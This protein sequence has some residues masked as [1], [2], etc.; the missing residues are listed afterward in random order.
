MTETKRGPGRPKKT[1]EDR[2]TR[3]PLGV[4][5]SKLSVEKKDPNYNYRW[6]NE[7]GDRIPRALEAGYEFVKRDSTDAPGVRD[8]VPQNSDLGTNVSKIVGTTEGGKPLT[9]YLMRIQKSFYQE[10]QKSKA[11]YV[12][13]LE[14]GI[15]DANSL[16]GAIGDHAYVKSFSVKR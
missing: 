12:D 13:S 10:D 5:R 15:R 14:A 16:K 9:A 1:A 4:P 7:T 11:E 8:V 3:V 6:I 2:P